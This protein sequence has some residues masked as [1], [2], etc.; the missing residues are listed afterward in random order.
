MPSPLVDAQQIQGNILR[1]FGGA[2]QAFVALSFRNDRVRARRW[3]AG[4]ASRVTGHDA[5]PPRGSDRIA[6]GRSLLNVGLTASGVVLLHPEAAGHLAV[7]TAYWQG[8]LGTRVDD[9]DRLTTAPVLLGDVGA[10]DP[11]AWVVG[12]PRNDERRRRGT[13]VDALLTIA[14]ADEAS[15]KAAV[16][17]E[18][19]AADGLE[20]LHVQFCEVLRE[21]GETGR[22]IEHFGFA[23]GISQPAVKGFPDAVTRPGA[24]VIAAGEFILGQVGERRPQ[25]WAPR[26][27]PARW[28]RGGSFQVYRRLVQHPDRF[29]ARMAELGRLSGTDADTAASHAFGR[30]RDGKPLAEPGAS[31]EKENV[32]TYDDDRDGEQTPLFAHIRKVNP[33][34]DMVFRDRGHKMLRRGITFG[35]RYHRDRPDENAGVERGVVFNAYVASIE[36][37]FE[38]VQRRWANDP[39]FPSS[40]LAKYGRVEAEPPRVDGLDPVIGDDRQT[41]EKRLPAAVVDKIKPSAFGGFVTTTGA[42]YAFAPT[43]SALRQLAGDEVLD[44]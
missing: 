11:S 2:H 27:V 3:L 20:I 14:A 28:M 44:A 31:G 15:I 6:Q 41:A 39:G 22:R 9:A 34:D 33:R 38:F 16:L 37:Q 17:H 21:E 32:F 43:L 13:P 36:D 23:D 1:P 4:V 7:H 40:A 26:P 25:S 29:W 42:V 24:P 19:T 5:V 10:G 30:H 8:P 12:G 35:P 18:E